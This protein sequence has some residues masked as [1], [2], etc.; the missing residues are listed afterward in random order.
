MKLIFKDPSLFIM[1]CG[2]LKY[3]NM[4]LI[5]QKLVFKLLGECKDFFFVHM[6]YH[7]ILMV[8]LQNVCYDLFVRIVS[9]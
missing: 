8:N 7:I 3:L 5:G 4:L 1:G 2:R 6:A 9:H